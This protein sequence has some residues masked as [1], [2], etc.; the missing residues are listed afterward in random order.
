MAWTAYLER[1]LKPRGMALQAHA[2]MAEGRDLKPLQYQSLKVPIVS[3]R[4]N[5]NHLQKS[6][7]QGRNRSNPIGQDSSAT[8]WPQLK[9][10]SLILLYQ[11]DA[12]SPACRGQRTF[13]QANINDQKNDISGAAGIPERFQ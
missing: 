6:E 5:L 13:L 8:V 2:I 7:R 1:R 12:C 11:A 10:I 9:R 4:F 3:H